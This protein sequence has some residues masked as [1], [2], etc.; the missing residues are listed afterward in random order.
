MVLFL[1]STEPFR[2]SSVR[3][4]LQLRDNRDFPRLGGDLAIGTLD[5]LRVSTLFDN[6]LDV[7]GSWAVTAKSRFGLRLT[8]PLSSDRLDGRTVFTTA[9]M[10]A[11]N[12]NNASGRCSGGKERRRAR[13]RRARKGTS[14]GVLL[15]S[16]LAMAN[17]ASAECI[18]IK[19]SESCPA[20]S[21]AS[22][23][24]DA[25]TGGL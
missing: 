5:P 20:W 15:L 3:S 17:T 12:S 11:T 16:L 7:D 21:D 2:L 8:L 19:D 4:S 18:S 10:S 23:S 24:A 1:S 13:T 6:C 25:K 22:I 9:A 14:A